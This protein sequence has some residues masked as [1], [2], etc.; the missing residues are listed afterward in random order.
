M[1]MAKKTIFQRQS[2]CLAVKNVNNTAGKHA[3]VENWVYKIRKISDFIK[4]L[5]NT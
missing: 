5:G 1:I 4:L 2:A 3:V